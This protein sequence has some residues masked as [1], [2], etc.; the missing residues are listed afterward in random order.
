MK[1]YCAFSRDY[2]NLMEDCSYVQPIHAG[3]ALPYEI[4]FLEETPPGYLRDDEGEGSREISLRN[5]TLSELTIHHYIWKHTTDDPVGI[6]HYRRIFSPFTRRDLLKKSLR[7]I[8]QLLPYN[9]LPRYEIRQILSMDPEGAN[10]KKMLETVD[11]ISCVPR[12][13]HTSLEGHYYDHHQPY[14]WPVLKTAFQSVYPYEWRSAFKFF[15]ASHNFIPNIMFVAKRRYINAFYEWAFP[16]IFE[17]EK[18][19]FFD[20]EEEDYQRRAVAFFGER[21]LCW[22]LQ[23]RPTS[24]AHLPIL[25]PKDSFEGDFHAMTNK[26]RKHTAADL[27]DV[28]DEEVDHKYAGELARDSML[29]YSPKAGCFMKQYLHM[30][31]PTYSGPKDRTFYEAFYDEVNDL[32]KPNYVVS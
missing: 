9:F 27:S 13:L 18:R 6:C 24:R 26:L 20:V 17:A 2:P 11:V 12:I 15:A 10:L 19:L 25:C 22:W 7:K 8:D 29:K 21:L 32:Y 23:S 4:G 28:V 5:R 30:N 3:A 31:Q 1:I 14:H 16:I